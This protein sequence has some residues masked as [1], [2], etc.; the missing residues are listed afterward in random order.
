MAVFNLAHN[1]T[2]HDEVQL[3][4][5]GRYLSSNEAVWR[6]LGFPIHERLPTVIHLSVHLE[7]VQRVYFTTENVLERV[8]VP[9][10]TT[11][12]AFFILCQSD[13]FA[14]TLLCHQ[15]PKYYTWNARNSKWDPRKSGQIVPENPGIKSSD[16]LGRVYTVHPSNSE[17]FHLRLLLHVVLGPTSFSDLKTINKTL[18]AFEDKIKG[19][20]GTNLKVFGLP[21]AQC[22]VNNSLNYE[23]LRETSYDIQ[24]LTSYIATNEPNLVDDQIFAFEK[25]T[26][27]I[28][29]ETGGIFFL[30]TPGGTGKTYLINLLLEKVR[31]RNMIALALAFS[32]IAATLLT[33]GR[34]AHLVFKLPLNLPSVENPICNIPSNSD[35]AE[36]LRMCKLI[37]WDECTMAHKYALEAS[38]ATMKDIFQN[39]KYM[40]GVTLVLSIDFRQTFT[41]YSTW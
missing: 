21:E 6:I 31:E 17:C 27:S 33:G 10:E 35:K 34:T 23:I 29:T 1:D 5:I 7:N 3:Y 22:D 36:V 38:D 11:L 20:R 24:K 16:A 9:P 18:I 25:I 13:E 15:V 4:E 26:S 41:C 32:G 8:Q 37:V 39:D 40:S 12:T 19:M 30:D 28:F 14:R 2:Q